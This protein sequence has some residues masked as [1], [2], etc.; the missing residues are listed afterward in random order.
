MTKNKMK[1]SLHAVR[2][3]YRS[4]YSFKQHV[5]VPIRGNWEPLRGTQQGQI[6]LSN[7]IVSSKLCIAW[8][9]WLLCGDW[10]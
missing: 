5:H 2:I 7:A 10:F 8:K 9:F 4:I 3:L 1:F 6:L